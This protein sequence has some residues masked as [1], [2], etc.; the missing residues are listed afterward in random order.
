MYV[1]VAILNVLLNVLNYGLHTIYL[2]ME[3]KTQQ[4]IYLDLSVIPGNGTCLS[5]LDN[6]HVYIVTNFLLL[7]NGTCFFY[8]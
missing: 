1:Y 5:L 8:C 6:L 4:S 2:K 3:P 7:G